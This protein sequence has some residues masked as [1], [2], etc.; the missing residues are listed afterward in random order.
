MKNSKGFTLIEILIVIAMLGA[1][2]VALL[3]TLDPIEQIRK[4]QDAGVRNI[5]KEMSDGFNRYYAQT[6]AMPWSTTIIAWG[7]ITTANSSYI[8]SVVKAGELKANFADTAKNYYTKIYFA[9]EAN[10]TNMSVCF[11]PTS[12]SFK[13]DVNAMFGAGAANGTVATIAGCGTSTSTC[14]WCAR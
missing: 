13:S 7:T 10:N 3:A 6:Y 9:S 4:S 8:S 11:Q 2:A 5:V 12:K 1:L 14:F